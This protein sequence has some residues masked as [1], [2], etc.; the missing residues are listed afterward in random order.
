MFAQPDWPPTLGPR[1]PSNWKLSRKPS[2]KAASDRRRA[3]LRGISLYGEN[4]ANKHYAM[5]GVDF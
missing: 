4:L 3:N 2:V 1:S 5:Q